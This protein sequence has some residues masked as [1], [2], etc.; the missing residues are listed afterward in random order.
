MEILGPVTVRKHHLQIY[1]DNIIPVKNTSLLR[2]F[3]LTLSP[4]RKLET[5][6]IF[7]YECDRNCVLSKN[8]EKQ[9]TILSRWSRVFS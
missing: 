4:L 5:V 1:P 2:F 9:D 7:M 6:P 3:F 8:E